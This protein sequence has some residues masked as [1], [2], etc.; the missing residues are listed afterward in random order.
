VVTVCSANS[1][2][3]AR[4]VLDEAN[5][6]LLVLLDDRGK[7]KRTYQAPGTPTTYL[8]GGDGTILMYHI[9]AVSEKHR[10]LSGELRRLLV[11]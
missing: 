10:Y 1:A 6:R 11:D 4:D 9:G 8:I 5:L 3:G 7:M 2:D